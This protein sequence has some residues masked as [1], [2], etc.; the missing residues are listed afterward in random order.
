MAQKYH[1]YGIDTS[2]GQFRFFT[3]GGFFSLP[4]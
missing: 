1:F 3:Y 2:N 4:E